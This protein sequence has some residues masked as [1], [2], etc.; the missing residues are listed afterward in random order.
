MSL[1]REEF[2]AFSR[3]ILLRLVGQPQH[4]ASPVETAR[5]AIALATEHEK[6]LVSSKTDKEGLTEEEQEMLAQNRLISAIKSVRHRLGIPLK[7]AKA[8]VDRYRYR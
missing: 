1:T 6:Q 8:V 3:Q 5:L 4:T 7:D 2:E